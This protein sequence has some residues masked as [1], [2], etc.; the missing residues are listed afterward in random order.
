MSRKETRTHTQCTDTRAIAPSAHR[1]LSS[2]RERARTHT[3]TH[4]T[5]PQ[6][7]TLRLPCSTFLGNEPKALKEFAAFRPFGESGRL[8][9]PLKNLLGRKESKDKDVADQGK[10]NAKGA[11]LTLEGQTPAHDTQCQ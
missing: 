3:H 2:A 6:L 10:S 7:L 11:A 9:Q 4:T 8:F 5:P 1:H